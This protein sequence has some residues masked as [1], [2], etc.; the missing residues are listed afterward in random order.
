MLA[1]RQWCIKRSMS[2]AAGLLFG[3][4]SQRHAAPQPGGDDE[5]GVR[6]LVRSVFRSTIDRIVHHATA[7][8][9]A[10]DSC[11]RKAPPRAA[12]SPARHRSCHEN[13]GRR[14]TDRNA[15]VFLLSCR[16]QSHVRTLL[17][18]S[19]AQSELTHRELEVLQLIARGMRNKE[20]AA[21]LHISEQ[22]VQV[23]VKNIRNKL[24]VHDRTAAV[25]VAA[26]R[27]IIRIVQR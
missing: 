24:D 10:G 3:F 22:T 26:Q 14:D 12:K 2:A 13:R 21:S 19:T 16:C 6:A 1:T 7:L 23:H 20:I 5:S 15:R 25:V 4:I 17:R 9:T 18:R 27:G 8:T 11:R